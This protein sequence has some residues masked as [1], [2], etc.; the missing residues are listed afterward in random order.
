MNSVYI[1]VFSA[2]WLIIAYFWYGKR[3]LQRKLVEPLDQNPCPSHS[4]QDGIDFYPADKMVLFGHHFSSIA[5]AGPIVGPIVAVTFFGWGPAVLWLLV[6]GVFIGAI[7]DYL[8]LIIS[9]RHSG[10]SIPDT[11]RVCFK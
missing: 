8:S 4:M 1:L 11:K 10:V 2:L 6:A 3:V 9:V 5:G 7:H